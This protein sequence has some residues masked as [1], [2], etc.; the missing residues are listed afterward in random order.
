[1]VH[2]QIS[3]WFNRMRQQSSG[4]L[5]IDLA[6]LPHMITIPIP[7]PAI[8]LSGAGRSF[9]EST[10]WPLLILQSNSAR[11][12]SHPIHDTYH[13]STAPYLPREQMLSA[14]Y[15]EVPR[16]MCCI[17]P[18]LPPR[19]QNVPLRPSRL[20][21]RSTLDEQPVG[22][23][24]FPSAPCVPVRHLPTLLIPSALYPY[25]YLSVQ[26]PRLLK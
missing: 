3:T 6:R 25:M 10:H 5:C 20:C 11:L 22:W 1:M 7:F 23:V 24:P 16:C 15:R 26:A 4:V 2:N 8:L 12:A 14:A 13:I 9:Y 18:Y 21:G 19:N 17:S